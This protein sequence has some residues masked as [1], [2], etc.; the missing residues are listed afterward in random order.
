MACL[1]AHILHKKK[2]GN[3]SRYKFLETLCE[4]LIKENSVV[5]EPR[6][7]GGPSLGENPLRLTARHFPS[8]VHHPPQRRRKTNQ[9][10]D[11]MS[12]LPEIRGRKL[13]TSAGS[14]RNHHALEFTIQNVLLFQC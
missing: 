14:V 10:A 7:K 13:F 12:V 1:N 9:P 5:R 6:R 8:T 2:G 3:L 11:A 4:R